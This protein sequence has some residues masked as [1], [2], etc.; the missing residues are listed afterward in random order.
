MRYRFLAG[1][2][3]GAGVV[4]TAASACNGTPQP[5]TCTDIPDGGCPVDY[6]AD[7]CIDPTCD[8]LY[9]CTSSGWVQI[10]TCPPHPMPEAGPDVADVVEAACASDANVLADAPPG[11]LGGGCQPPLDDTDCQLGTALL[12]NPSCN[13]LNDCC[14]CQDLYVCVDSNWVLWGE[15][16]EAGVVPNGQ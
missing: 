4:V 16:T 13:P 10:G 6:D 3:L 9:S 2:V 14:G 8:T 5:P 15:C 12:C 11:A 7:F 1:L